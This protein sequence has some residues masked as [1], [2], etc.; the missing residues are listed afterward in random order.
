MIFL[1]T[2]GILRKVCLGN[3]PAQHDLVY[4]AV[5]TPKQPTCTLS[6][7]GGDAVEIH[8]KQISYKSAA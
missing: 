1:F 3:G 8:S 6:L 4:C 2:G 7:R 5:K